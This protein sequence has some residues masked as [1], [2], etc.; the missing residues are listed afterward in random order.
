MEDSAA[1][2]KESMEEKH[3]QLA[4]DMFQKITEYLNGELAG[5]LRW[6]QFS[7]SR[8][9]C[10]FPQDSEVPVPLASG[11]LVSWV[12]R[13]SLICIIQRV[14]EHFKASGF[15]IIIV[16]SEEYQLLLRLN[17]MTIA[18]YSDMTSLAGRLNQVSEKLNEKCKCDSKETVPL[19][20]HVVQSCPSSL[21]VTR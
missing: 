2:P 18:K 20:C 4:T 19:L 15:L 16:T 11:T 1:E 13:E 6:D 21:T 14:F 12:E 7:Y 3:K 9:P 10:L 5:E 8:V 17:Q